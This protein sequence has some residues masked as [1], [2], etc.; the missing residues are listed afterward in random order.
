MFDKTKYFSAVRSVIPYAFD[1]CQ[2]RIQ[3][4]LRSVFIVKSADGDFIC[5]FNHREMA[6]KNATVAS[7]LLDHGV[8]A[9]QISVH[10]YKEF[11]F[12]LYPMIRGQTLYEYVGQGMNYI[13]MQHAYKSLVDGFAR[14]D[15]INVSALN[16]LKYKYTHQVAKQNITDTNNRIM[17]N[18]F[19]GAVRLM[20]RGTNAHMGVYHCG[21]TPKNVI[22]DENGK[23]AA[24]LDLDEVAIA[25]I[26]YAF[27]MMAGKYQ[28]IGNNPMDLVDYYECRT[29]RKLNHKK[30]QKLANLT[31]VG[32]YLLWHNAKHNRGK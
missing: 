6:I 27:A 24:L 2:P 8:P 7:V 1:I 22:L 29:G 4:S 16:D 5:K 25:D 3:G 15:E 31:N 19:S 28:K 26:N 32:K 30:I 9:P 18:V 23:F 17:A 11:W 12:E 10:N 13:K 21:I 14:M 20:N